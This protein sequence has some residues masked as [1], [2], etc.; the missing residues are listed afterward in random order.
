MQSNIELFTKQVRKNFPVNRGENTCCVCPLC[1]GL[2]NIR[3][4]LFDNRFY[5]ICYNC[6]MTI[7]G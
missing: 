2:I 7:R 5:A 1:K 3:R 6:K 4:H